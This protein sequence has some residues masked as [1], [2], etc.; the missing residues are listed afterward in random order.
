MDEQKEIIEYHHIYKSGHRGINEVT[1]AVTSKYYWPKMS[2]DIEHFINNCEV[3][4][5]NKYDRD[6]P[7]LKFNL[8]PTA[9]KPFEHIHIDVF[10]ISNSYYL[11]IIDA[12]SRYG[13]AYPIKSI[14]GLAIVE[15]FLT[16]VTHH[17]LPKIITADSGSEF[18]NNDLQ[19]FC[20]L[21]GIELH[22]TTAKNSNS[23]SLVERL[24]SSLIEHFRCLREENKH[25]T[26]D[27]L[28][29]YSIL[30]YNNSIHSVTKLTPFEIIKGHLDNP[31][32]FDLN[33]H[34]ILST[35]VQDHKQLTKKLYQ[36]IHDKNKQTKEKIIE[37][38]NE[39][40][41][42]P[43]EYTN[44]KSVYIK[45]KLRDKKLPKFK[46]CNLI[47]DDNIKL[48]TKSGTYHKSTA[49]KPRQTKRNTLLQDAEDYEVNNPVPGPS[50]SQ[51]TEK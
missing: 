48:K 17:G 10:H 4:L 1:V 40:R 5:K 13:Q 27:Q 49:R 41:S 22:Y 38:R 47:S 12:F 44:Q 30:S 34:L 32:P 2:Q 19:N 7:T 18:K 16:F 26:P 20:K 35:Y 37:K 31:D 21:H 9:S 8:T 46:K 6:P 29:K 42:D 33:D 15:S 36:E 23:N 51:P 45:T 43:P 11:T 24:H 25:F 3:C 50:R 14:T 39:N 28:M